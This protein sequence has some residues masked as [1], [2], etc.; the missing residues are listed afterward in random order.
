MINPDQFFDDLLEKVVNI[1]STNNECEDNLEKI[2]ELL[3]Q[4]VSYYD[5]VG[6]YIVNP[7]D[8]CELVLGPFTGEHTEHTRIKFGHGIC[9]QVAK[10]QKTMI[11]QNVSAEDNYL[12]CSPFVKS[13]IVLPVF[14]D[15]LFIGELDID[16]HTPEPFSEL[17]ERFLE[18]VCDIAGRL[19]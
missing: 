10:S 13:E 17:D 8:E 18:K 15:G 7:L 4:S 16:S 1:A 6:F 9:G 19:F 11:I 12:S 2:T 5:W 14:V 3:K